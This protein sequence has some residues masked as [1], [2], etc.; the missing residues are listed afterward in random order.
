MPRSRQGSGRHDNP[1]VYGALYAS[2]SPVGAVAERIQG[3]RG[4]RLAKGDLARADGSPYVLANLDNAGIEPVVDLDDPG[5]LV[6]RSLRPSGVATRHRRS[7]QRIAR[8]I[9]DE[10]AVGL[11][12]WST[13][14][15]SW[16]N[17][18]FFVASSR[19][20][21]LTVTGLEELTLQHPAVTGAADALG[22]RI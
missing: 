20:R 15:A 6:R 3:L 5:E 4:Q 19:P 1:D 14:E 22:I 11:G 13:L 12:W 7:T 9:Y 10:G 18:T 21:A 8:A 2:R 17:V 16:P